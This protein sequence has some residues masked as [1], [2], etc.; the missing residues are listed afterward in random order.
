MTLSP[1]DFVDKISYEVDQ[2]VNNHMNKVKPKEL[3][4]DSRAG[5]NLYVKEDC[6]AVKKTNDKSLQYYGGFEYIDET[7]RFE[8]GTYVF[9]FNDNRV[10]SAI[11]KYENKSNDEICA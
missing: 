9:Y 6:I 4:L 7:D 11:E 8:L 2:Y 3:G 10:L 5:Y 1:Y